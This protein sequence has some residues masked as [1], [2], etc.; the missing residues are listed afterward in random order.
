[1]AQLLAPADLIAQVTSALDELADQLR[2]VPAADY[3]KPSSA[4]GLEH[5]AA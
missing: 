5:R 2:G 3:A 4:A 1:M